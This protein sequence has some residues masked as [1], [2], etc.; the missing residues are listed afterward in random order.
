MLEVALTGALGKYFVPPILSAASGGDVQR[1]AKQLLD[2]TYGKWPSGWP[3]SFRNLLGGEETPIAIG[4]RWT[5]IERTIGKDAWLTVTPPRPPWPLVRGRTPAIVTFH[6]FK[7]GVGRTT[8][9]AAHAIRAASGRPPR[10]VAVLD[11]DLEAP[12]IGS[13]LAA[14]TERGVLDVLVDHIATGEVNL[15]GA[16]SPARIDRA[17]DDQITVFSAGR[18]DDS[19]LQ[20]LA[21]LDFSSTEPGKEN[22]VGAAL[23]AM[24]GA[25][26]PH[27]DVI[28][29]DSRAG[30]HDIAGMSLHGLAHVHVLVF[31][32]TRQHLIGLG[33]TLR[34]LGAQEASKLVLVE[35]MLPN[36][37]PVFV[38]HRERV[39]GQVYELLC[40][41][42]YAEQDPP[43]LV[44]NGEPH[45]VVSVHRREWLD[46]MDSLS[47]QV[48][49]VQK[50][51]D[52]GEVSRR[53]DD[54]CALESEAL[55]AGE[56]EEIE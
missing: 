38:A 30:L 28:L 12:G 43:Q 49:R 20:K 10:R 56:D 54:E 1:L 31:R 46:G 52:L 22:R 48:E 3:R 11:L 17:I 24:L 2:Q 6:S 15:D 23:A 9:A 34:V 26:K 13:L 37:E 51:D 55:D 44:D 41:H 42:V 32:G 16:S 33:Q 21:R 4:S 14:E 50:D 19:Y 47:G 45:D 7:G 27:F 35:T 53:V 39:R 40:E 29:L 8:L 5:G 25:M 18:P 36:D